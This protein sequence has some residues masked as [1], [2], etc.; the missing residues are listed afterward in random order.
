L[1]LSHETAEVKKDYGGISVFALSL[2]T[3]NYI[4]FFPVHAGIIWFPVLMRPGKY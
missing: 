1:D 3:H 2:S 4:T